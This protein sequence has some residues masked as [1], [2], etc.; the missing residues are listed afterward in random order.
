[1]NRQ[2][3]EDPPSADD[4]TVITGPG[5][6][7]WR[8]SEQFYGEGRYWKDIW[9]RNRKMID[10]DPASLPIGAKLVIPARSEFQ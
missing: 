9:A 10:S 7:L 3:P 8:I 6:S 2:S 5:S 4:R 1:L